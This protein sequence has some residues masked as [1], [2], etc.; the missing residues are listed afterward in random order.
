[1]NSSFPTQR[2]ISC[3]TLIELLVVIAII[4]ILA[5]MLL[6]ALQ[7]ARERGRSASCV[8]N[9]KQI[10]MGAMAY[11]D[12]MDGFSL[13]QLTKGATLTTYEH[14]YRED[15]WLASYINGSTTVAVEKWFGD[16]SIMTCPSRQANNYG[17]YGVYYHSYALNRRVQ[18]YLPLE[19]RKVTLLKRP[20]FYIA[21]TDSETYNFDRGSFWENRPLAGKT[22]NRVDFRHNGN[23]VFNA[24]H[25]DGHIAPY[26]NSSEWWL[27]AKSG[28]TNLP[29]YKK[30]DPI[31][32]KENWPNPPSA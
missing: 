31:N 30:I 24:I 25:A 11:S 23:K 9:L 5:A 12:Q 2:R 29:H 8:N 13:P 1:M 14:W 3:F 15:N 27:P 26:S 28:Y 6:P 4:A 7:S 22:A 20:S 18:G 10:S 16:S 17:K 32:N 19:A 21:F